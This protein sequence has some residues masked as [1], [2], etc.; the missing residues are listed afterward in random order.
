VRMC[1]GVTNVLRTAHGIF[2][3][4]KG[5]D[6]PVDLSWGRGRTRLW[7]RIRPSCSFDRCERLQKNRLG[8][9]TVALLCF[10]V[11]AECDDKSIWRCSEK[12]WMC[13]ISRALALAAQRV[14]DIR[15]HSRT[16]HVGAH[17]APT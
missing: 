14:G 7:S 1:E 6:V 13:E 8:M 10:G 9:A 15:V 16:V 17:R 2:R 11:R 12:T 4:H 3:K 5:I